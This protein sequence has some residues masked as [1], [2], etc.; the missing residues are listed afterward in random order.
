MRTDVKNALRS[1]EKRMRAKIW[2]HLTE[3]T[4]SCEHFLK[5]VS[6]GNT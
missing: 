5:C 6:S 4:K 3:N 2:P 1:N